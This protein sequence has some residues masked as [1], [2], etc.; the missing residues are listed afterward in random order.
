MPGKQPG[1][2]KKRRER[3]DDGI[4]WDKTNRCYEGTISLGYGADGKRLRRTV[5]GKTKAEVKDKL[6]E[7][8]KEIEA[9][10]RTPATYTVWQCVTDWLDDLTFD[11]DTVAQYRG[12]A[13][14][15]IR[16]RI[17]HVKLKEFS[18]TDA[19]K[20]FKAIAGSLSKRSLL[21]VKST[22]RRAIRRAQV[23]DLIGKNVVELIDLPPGQ[24][25]RPSRAMT[26][27]QAGRVLATTRNSA[28]RFT[29]VTKIGKAKTAATHAAA[30]NGDLA[31]GTRP[32]T[33]TPAQIFG[34]DLNTVTCRSCRI[35]LGLDE[36]E[37]EDEALRLEALFVLAITL[38][39]R[40]GELRGL[41]WD[42]VDLDRGVI[43][44]WRSARKG[45]DVKTPKSRR[46]LKLPKRAL[47]TLRK[48]KQRQASE[49]EAAGSTW[50]DNNL[51][52]CH[53][54]G[55]RYTRDALNWRFSKMTKRAGIGHWHAHEARHTAVS[56]MS[57]NDVPIQDISDAMGHKSTHVTETVYRHV[58]AP[59]IRGG[60][61][62]MDDIFGDQDGTDDGEAKTA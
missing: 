42:L 41:A 37:H 7:L 54:D 6:D 8:H 25:G 13:N 4:H 32:R 17:G 23:H 33:G 12:Q 60:A 10:I 22:L 18:A 28:I 3:G 20:F 26:E 35:Q 19:D 11:E 14:K 45:G 38:G 1:E 40:P 44:V 52:F 30:K 59:A 48:H 24:P 50:Q 55:R 36:D 43:R 34:Q 2:P 47:E 46:S 53:Q 5:S 16:P 61:S 58:I 9:G 31:C 15:W 39:L 49:H 27:E 57:H 56:I 62:V 29:T 51:V 21:M